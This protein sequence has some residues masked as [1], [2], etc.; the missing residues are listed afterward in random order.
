MSDVD[1]SYAVFQNMIRISIGL[2]VQNAWIGYT[3]YVKP[4]SSQGT[5]LSDDADVQCLR[6]RSCNT[7]KCLRDYSV[8]ESNENNEHQP[9]I[10]LDIAELKGK[11]EALHDSIDSNIGDFERQY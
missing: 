8:A 2:S 10:A 5:S 4:F 3:A 1:L 7:E 6:C 9:K 11:W